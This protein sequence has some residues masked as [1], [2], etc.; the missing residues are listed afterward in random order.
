MYTPYGRFDRPD[1]YDLYD[2]SPVGLIENGTS[3]PPS[4]G[5]LI[6]PQ[7]DVEE[8]GKQSS[9]GVVSAYPDFHGFF[10]TSKGSGKVFIPS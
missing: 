7:M 10:Q 8:L 2:N 1:R 6:G 4:G 3:A 5:G 9:S